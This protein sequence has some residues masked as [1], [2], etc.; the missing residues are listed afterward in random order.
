MNNAT[1][2]GMSYFFWGLILLFAATLIFYITF[3]SLVY[4]WHERKTTFVVVPLIY[5]FEFFIVGFFLVA[6]ISL[7]LQYTP[8][9]L[10]LLQSS[11]NG[12]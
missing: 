1:L 2:F 6:L 3:V 4:Y 12:S 9:L 10:L 11:A 7:V 5:T 8:Q